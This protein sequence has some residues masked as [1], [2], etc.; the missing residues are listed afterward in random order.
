VILAGLRAIEW[1]KLTHA[2]GSAEDVPDLLEALLAQDDDVVEESLYHL[3]YN[4]THQGTLYEATACTVPFLLAILQDD[5]LL[6]GARFG[7]LELIA[8]IVNG[9]AEREEVTHLIHEA[10]KQGLPIYLAL[11]WHG[12]ENEADT[13]IEIL[14]HLPE[15]AATMSLDFQQVFR[16]TGLADQQVHFCM[17]FST[18]LKRMKGHAAALFADQ[19]SYARSCLAQDYPASV[20]LALAHLL[21]L[22]AP[23]Q[24]D[25]AAIDLLCA[26]LAQ[27]AAYHT[28]G[29]TPSNDVAT[30]LNTLECLPM[31]ARLAALLVWLPR[32]PTMLTAHEVGRFLF[33]TVFNPDLLYGYRAIQYIDAEGETFIQYMT[34]GIKRVLPQQRTALNSDQRMVVEALVNF[35]LFWKIKTN[36]LEVFGLPGKREDLRAYLAGLGAS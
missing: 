35:D 4:I 21:V 24:H 27:P 25:T 11:L 3:S 12:T 13:S 36:L 6:A 8:S 22:A 34:T 20:R 23:Q 7:A 5:T 30:I 31:S 10:A 26:A 28:A 15:E 16:G 2:Y 19:A 17:R 29:S 33:T 14:N 9:R 32:I 1:S 18:L